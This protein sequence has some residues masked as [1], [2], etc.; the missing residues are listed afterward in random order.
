ME[1]IVLWKR[2]CTKT[3]WVIWVYIWSSESWVTS[4]G[5]HLARKRSVARH[6]VEFDEETALGYGAKLH[7]SVGRIVMDLYLIPGWFMLPVLVNP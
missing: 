4:G 1:R 5:C 6:I 7:D 3:K 2:Y